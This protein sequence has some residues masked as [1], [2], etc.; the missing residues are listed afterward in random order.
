[1][2]PGTLTTAGTF[3]TEPAAWAHFDE[4]VA[5]NG[6]FRM[7]REV[8]GEYIQPRVSTEDK[9]ARVDRLLIP[10]RPAI[11]AGWMHGAIVV[12]GKKSGHGVGK[13]ITQALD[14]SRCVWR[15]SE[16]V[17]GLLIATTWT[18]VYP[19]E[20]IVGDFESVMVQNRVGYCMAE[21]RRVVFGVGGTNGLVLWD[22]G[23]VAVKPLLAGRKRGSR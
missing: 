4:L 14:Y 8:C 13:L 17:P 22:D 11:D 18:F 9:T 16:G 12:E 3:E 7:H 15:L 5:A 21:R 2:T 23:T 6:A 1:M 19:V 20:R 10:L